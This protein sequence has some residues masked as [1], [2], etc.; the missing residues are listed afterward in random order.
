MPTLPIRGVGDVGVVTDISAAHLPANA[1]TRGKNIR[2]DEGAVVRAPVFRTVET[3]TTNKP[4]FIFS[5]LSETGHG[6]IIF[7]DDKFDIREYAAGNFTPKFTNTPALSSS[8]EPFTGTS[9]AEAIYINRSDRVPLYVFGS[10]CDSLSSGTDGWQSTWRTKSIRAYGDF[11]LALNMTEGAQQRPNRVRWSDLAL[12]S[13]SGQF[14]EPTW[15]AADP[16]TSAGFNDIVQ[17]KTGIVDGAQLGSNFVIYSKDQIWLM[18]F[19][20]GTFIFNFRKLFQDRGLINQNCVV[21][22]NGR[23]YCF[24]TDDI[25][26]HDGNTIT[27][28]ADQRVKNYVFNGIASDKLKVCFVHHNPVLEEIYFCYNSQDDLHEFEGGT[29]CNRAAVY[30]YKND[31][32]SFMDMPNV[33]SATMASLETTLA[34]NTASTTTYEGIGGTYF[35]QESEFSLH[36]IFGGETNPGGGGG[37]GVI[38]S[39]RL[40][41][42][43]GSEQ[44]SKVSLP[45][46]SGATIPPFIERVGI[47]IDEQIQLS[48][49]KVI[50]KVVPQLHS[51]NPNKQFNFNFGA[52]DLITSST[53]YEPTVTFD[54][55]VSHKIDTRS[56]GR[57]LSYKMTTTDDKDFNFLGFDVDLTMTGRR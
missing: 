20:G 1:F 24:G 47:D 35:S 56:A 26:A 50:T 49:Y 18:S 42:L 52:A 45:V 16:T 27:S 17:M 5:R 23:H 6:S 57:Y 41:A 10:D 51:D 19:V 14:D 8:L 53:T 22:V 15:N 43:D 9:L 31:T 38:S 46:D 25:Y 39:N 34:Y 40:Y 29:R 33:N 37:P 36:N 28:I 13:G 7:V 48:G 12:M 21:E 30:N 32:W 11:L 4:R 2:F 55:N 44:N 3:N 54:A